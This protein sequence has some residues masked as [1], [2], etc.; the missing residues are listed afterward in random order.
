MF[1]PK[2]PFS[3]VMRFF[4]KPIASIQLHFRIDQLLTDQG[5]GTFENF[6]ALVE[7]TRLEATSPGPTQK[8]FLPS[9]DYTV[10]TFSISPSG[11]VFENNKILLGS[12]PMGFYEIWA[13]QSSYND[14]KTAGVI[15]PPYE[16][17]PRPQAWDVKFEQNSNK[18]KLAYFGGTL[19][20]YFSFDRTTLNF[21]TKTPITTLKLAAARNKKRE[22]DQNTVMGNHG[23]PFVCPLSKV[24]IC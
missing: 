9:S 20:L 24:E 23:A 4:D 21:E 1:P 14:L 10:T 15:L 8:H 22:P 17:A 12:H 5:T 11:G 16:F 19:P 18:V 13:D 7:K 3:T 2:E 6:K